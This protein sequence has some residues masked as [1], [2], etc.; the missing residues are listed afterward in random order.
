MENNKL[1]EA[2]S[3][4]LIT[5]MIQDSRSRLARNSGT[6]FLIWGYTTVAVS[7]FNALALYLGWSHAWAW[8]W[9]SIPV[10]GWLGMMLLFKQEPSARNYIDRIVSMIWVVIGLSFAW[11]F[12][13]TVVFGC[14]ISFLTVVVMGIGTVLTGCVIKHRTTTICGWAAMCASLIFPIVYFIM[15]KSGSASAISEIWIWGELIVFALIFLV[16]MV[17]PGHILNHKYNK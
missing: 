6:P 14:S 15:A 7:L 3:L 17:I 16:M 13:G 1:S 10:I 4:E 8:S 9:F 11:L 12:V 2:Q 5:S